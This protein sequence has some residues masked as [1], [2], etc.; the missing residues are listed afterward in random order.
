MDMIFHADDY[1]ITA[2]QSQIILD[3]ARHGLLNS[4]S[5]LTTSP[6]FGEC[7][8]L[9]DGRPEDMR[10]G[11]HVNLVEG[12]CA[13]DPAD[14]PLLV[15][16]RGMFCQGFGGLL[17][18]SQGPRRAEFVRQVKVEV[19][20]QAGRFVERFPQ[21]CDAF[22]VDGHQHTQLIPA[23]F[24]AIMQ[25]VDE[26]GLR[27][28]YFRVPVEPLSAFMG[29][30]VRSTIR[31]IN[32]V[33]KVTLSS[34][35][36][37]DRARFADYEDKSA[38]FCGVLFSGSMDQERVR[39]VFPAY[40]QRAEKRGMDLEMLFHPG[41]LPS[42]EAC[43][44]PTGEGFVDFYLSEGRRIEREALSG[45][46]LEGAGGGARLVWEGAGVERGANA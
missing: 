19:A 20:A 41:G 32:M 24:D 34:L 25:V 40:V 23:V 44:D 7:A 8:D 1:G 13:A 12:P 35:W 31:P 3:C 43:L 16:E 22:R 37:M 42:A 4:T 21:T 15:D 11:L 5:V 39:K 17:K 9:L 18:L 14:V 36:L 27:L 30:D 29:S 26:A 45:L 46:K 28:E 38:L 10:I 33:K 2:D 6:A